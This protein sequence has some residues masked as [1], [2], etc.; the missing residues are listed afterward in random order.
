MPC[1]YCEKEYKPATSCIQRDYKLNDGTIVPAVKVGEANDS[2]SKG[3]N[4]GDCNA[5]YGAYHHIG[6]DVERCR[7]C[8]GQQ[9]YCS[10]NY[11]DEMI[12]YQN[13]E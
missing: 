4:C 10:C 9:I 7:L 13:A 11:S 12:V 8:G 2:T 1:K 6:C 3:E 5:P